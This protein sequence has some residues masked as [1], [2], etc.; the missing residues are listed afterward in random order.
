[1][2][3]RFRKVISVLPGVKINLSKSGV[4]TSLGGKGATVN[5]GSTGRRTLTLGIPG[6]GMSY[7]VPLGASVIV[8]LLAVAALVALA[9]FVFPLQVKALLHWW[10][11]RVF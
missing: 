10:Q 4:S 9:Y 3:F 5:V 1:M 11:P 2:G 8:L 7:Q 6:T